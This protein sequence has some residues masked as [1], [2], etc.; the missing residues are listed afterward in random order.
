MF[1]L[2]VLLFII[3]LYARNNIFNSINDFTV[4]NSIT[5]LF[6]IKERRRSKTGNNGRKNL[7]IVVPLKYLSN[8]WRTP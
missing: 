8:F 6:E 2:L 3:K 5:N 1:K 7:E 4:A